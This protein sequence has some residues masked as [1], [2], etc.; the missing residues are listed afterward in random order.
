MYRSVP[1]AD[2]S[3][4][5][6]LER[7]VGFRDLSTRGTT[8]LWNGRPLQVRGMLHWGF[9]PPGFAPD[10]DPAVWRRELERIRQLGCNLVKCCLWVPPRAFYETADCWRAAWLPMYC[11]SPRALYG[12]S[13]KAIPRSGPTPRRWRQS[14]RWRV[15]H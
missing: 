2:G 12:S 5:D 15:V 8:L 3:S 9:E 1:A 10:P 11:L 14:S 7:R 6:L 13:P 4:L